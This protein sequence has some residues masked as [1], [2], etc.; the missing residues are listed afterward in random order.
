MKTF[1][2]VE[3][4]HELDKNL[5]KEIIDFNESS[6]ELGKNWAAL[7]SYAYHLGILH[8]IHYANTSRG[9]L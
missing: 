8:G 6:I 7:F 1:S 4:K 5:F 9:N 3:A 2:E